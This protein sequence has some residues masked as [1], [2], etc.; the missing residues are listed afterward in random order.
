LTS[1]AESIGG[2]YKPRILRG[3][4]YVP[5]VNKGVRRSIMSMNPS[6]SFVTGMEGESTTPNGRANMPGLHHDPK[7]HF[8]SPRSTMKPHG[9]TQRKVMGLVP[10]ASF[11]D[12]RVSSS[13]AIKKIKI[14][15]NMVVSDSGDSTGSHESLPPPKQRAPSYLMQD[16][17]DSESTEKKNS[18]NLSGDSIASVPRS[19][20]KRE[21]TEVISKLRQSLLA[22]P[23]KD[24]ESM[25]EGLKQLDEMVNS[26]IMSHGTLEEE[27]ATLEDELRAVKSGKA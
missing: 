5:M 16:S 8:E 21:S 25:L 15:R 2:E 27:K 19:F 10:D 17:P 9:V 11:T 14:N 13:T 22:D 23:T 1:L 7:Q 26:T 4:N 6:A 18:V 3:Q 24:R 12:D 20:K